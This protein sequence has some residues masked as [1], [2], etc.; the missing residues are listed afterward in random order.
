MFSPP[1]SRASCFVEFVF[2]VYFHQRIRLVVFR[3]EVLTRSLENYPTIEGSGNSW[4]KRYNRASSRGPFSVSLCGA[5]VS[6]TTPPGSG[7]GF[8]VY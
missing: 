1:E 6:A 4:W 3:Q 5:A 2:E 7:P 8:L